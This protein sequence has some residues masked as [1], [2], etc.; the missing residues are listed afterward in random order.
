MLIEF[1]TFSL[2]DGADEAEF[3]AADAG[4]QT[5]Y[6][7]TRGFLRRTTARGTDGSAMDSAV[8]LIAEPVSAG[9]LPD[10]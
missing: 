7:S 4:L 8:L 5:L 3:L 1:R 10:P 2:R 9:C 6:S